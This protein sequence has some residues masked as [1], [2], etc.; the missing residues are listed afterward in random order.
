MELTTWRASVAGLAAAAAL[1][2]VF[3]GAESFGQFR[4]ARSSFEAPSDEV[5][6]AGDQRQDE[7]DD[8]PLP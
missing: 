7:R 6:D 5:N 8:D 2:K 3:D 4:G 1:A